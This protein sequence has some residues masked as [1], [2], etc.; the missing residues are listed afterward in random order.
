MGWNTREEVDRVG[1]PG[2]TY[3]WPCY[4]GT[5]HTVDLPGRRPLR[6]PGGE[7]SKEGTP[8]AHV[9]PV[10][11][12]VHSATNAIIGGPIYPGGPY[13]DSYDGQM[14]FGDYSAGFLKVLDFSGGG[15]P[16]ATPFA[17]NWGGVDLVLTPDSN[18]AFPDF[19]T[20]EPGTGSLKEI[21][22]EPSTGA[23]HAVATASPIAGGKPLHV[24]FSAAGST[25]P[26]RA[27][28]DL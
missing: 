22:Y 16:T 7:Y 27:G 4:E 14:F 1:T 2:H 21:V 18:I 11:D 25:D 26:G 9:P 13:P 3:G 17:T 19:G 8:D 28:A 12:Y 6:R 5:M 20:G 24:T 23:P 10:Y 15:T